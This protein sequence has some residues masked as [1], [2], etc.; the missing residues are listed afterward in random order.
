MTEMK[1]DEVNSH[2]AKSL[3]LTLIQLVFICLL[4]SA[5]SVDAFMAGDGVLAGE[6]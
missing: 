5:S 1:S 4:F 2:G 3:Q 6:G